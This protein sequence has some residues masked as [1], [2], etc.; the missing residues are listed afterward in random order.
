MF[1]RATDAYFLVPRLLQEKHVKVLHELFQVPALRLNVGNARVIGALVA[2]N[3]RGIVIPGQATEEEVSSLERQLD[4]AGLAGISVHL[5]DARDNALG[6]LVLA[7]DAGCV[8]S[9]KLVDHLDALEA[10]L[11]VPATIFEYAGTDL[12]GSAGLINNK[13][14]VVHPVA[15]DPEIDV[16]TR[17]LRVPVDV[18]TANCGDPFIGACAAANA[19]GGVVGRETTGPELQ[20]ISE[21]LE[22]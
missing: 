1:V 19:H 6:N 22:I 9:P 14:G 2:C 11:G 21:M 4:S 15:S 18:S 12:V 8:V 5:I 16:L 13:G 3:A 17:H 10:A 20:R 7:N